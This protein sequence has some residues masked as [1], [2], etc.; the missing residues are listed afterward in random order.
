ME[1]DYETR[2]ATAVLE[3]GNIFRVL[4][5]NSFFL[6]LGKSARVAHLGVCQLLD[7]RLQPRERISSIT[8]GAN[9]REKVE[10]RYAAGTAGR[11]KENNRRRLTAEVVMQEARTSDVG[12]NA[13]GNDSLQEP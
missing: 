13:N 12:A 4:L 5:E 10:K 8:S 2:K 1:E 7:K 11:K 6:S 3:S 9:E